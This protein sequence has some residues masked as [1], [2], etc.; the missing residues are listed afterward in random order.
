MLVVDFVT[1]KKKKTG[2]APIGHQ[3]EEKGQQKKK[4]KKKD[5]CQHERFTTWRNS[6][7]VST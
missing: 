2:T 1:R 4:K 3:V 5:I 7:I 6:H